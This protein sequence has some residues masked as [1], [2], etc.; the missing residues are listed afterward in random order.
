MTI[1]EWKRECCITVQDVIDRLSALP[2]DERKRKFAL[3][4]PG[5]RIGVMG[6]PMHIDEMVM[7]EGNL[8]PGSALEQA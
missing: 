2:A 4:M 1:D 6:Q 5:S 7:L 8:K 3:F